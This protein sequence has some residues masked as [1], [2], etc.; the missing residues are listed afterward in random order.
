MITDISTII[1]RLETLN[2]PIAYSHF[3]A[4]REPPFICYLIPD[5]RTDGADDLHTIKHNSVAI[6]LYTAQRDFKLENRILKLF[7]DV[8]FDVSSAYIESEKLFVTYFEFEFIE[9]L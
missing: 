6:E 9:K 1:R 4:A 3:A 8:E 5:S 7:S 2:V